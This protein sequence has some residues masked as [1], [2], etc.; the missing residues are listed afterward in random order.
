M[1]KIYKDESVIV[2]GESPLKITGLTPDTS[3]EKGTYQAT[4]IEGDRESERVDIPAFKTLPIKVTGVELTP[5]TMTG[6]VGKRET[7][8]LTATVAPENATNKA[9]TY[10]VTPNTE[11]ITVD[12]SGVLSW[13]EVVNVGEYT[14][15]V[16]T[17]D[18]NKT[19]TST[20]NLSAPEIPDPIDPEE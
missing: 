8:Q 16:K 18:G 20:I 3:V 11:G 19:A 2:E 4:R 7:R 9:V 1:Y 17:T 12:A 10:S 5:K 6:E 13:T 14:V 15:T